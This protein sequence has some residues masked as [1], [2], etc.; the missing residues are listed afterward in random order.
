MNNNQ[1]PKT[2]LSD[3][4]R[5]KKDLPKIIKKLSAED[6]IIFVGTSRVPW[7]ILLILYCQDLLCSHH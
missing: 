7:D 5:L 2:D 3:P 1:V 6:R 4:K